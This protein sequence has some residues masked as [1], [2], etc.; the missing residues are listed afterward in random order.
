MSISSRI[1]EDSDGS[2]S[3]NESSSFMM[4]ISIIA[5][6]NTS[7]KTA[8]VKHDKI[9]VLYFLSFKYGYINTVRYD[10]IAP[11]ISGRYCMW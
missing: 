1:I 5:G 11:I 9:I 4:F 10:S 3:I 8:I 6:I 2:N 7:D